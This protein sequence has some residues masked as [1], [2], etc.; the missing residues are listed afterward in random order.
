MVSDTQTAEP[1]AQSKVDRAAVERWLTGFLEA[2]DLPAVLSDAVRYALLGP[3][4]RVRPLLCLACCRAVGGRTEHA[5]PSA[6]CVELVHAFSLVHDD[7]PALDNDDLRRGR[8][9]LHVHAGEDA[10]ILAGDALLSL[11]MEAVAGSEIDPTCVRRLVAEA[12]RATTDMIAG[13]CYDTLGGAGRP[14]SGASPDERLAWLER[15]H[16]LKT[17]ALLTAACRMGA[18]AGGASGAELDAV[19]RFAESVGLLFQVVDDL[20]DATATSEQL[21]KA[22]RKDEDAGKL[23]YPGLLGIEGAEAEA[24]R[25]SERAGEAA[26]EI[27]PAGSEL[28]IWRRFVAERRR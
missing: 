9:T 2:R 21:G 18:I 6:G 7:L 1:P 10:A 4:K 23:T 13:Q 11:A 17:G 22:A 15:M 28:D 24:R 20:L 12:A 5:L 26:A 14:E 19:T 3:G 16:R 8:P 27:G 25:W